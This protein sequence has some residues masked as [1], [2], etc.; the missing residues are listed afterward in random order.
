MQRSFITA[1]GAVLA[2]ASSLCAP[3]IGQA[4]TT[5]TL[6]LVGPGSTTVTG[7]NTEGDQALTVSN[8]PTV[9]AYLWRRGTQTNIGGLAPSP[10]FV[11]SGGLNDLVQMVGTTICPKSGNFCGFVWSQGHMRE[12]PTPAGSMAAFGI[13]VNLLGQIVGQVYDANFNAQAALWNQGTLTLLP[14]IPGGSFSQPVGINIFG[15]IV[16]YSDDASNVPNT[17]L[18]RHGALT[19]LLK[20][21]IPGAVNDEGQIVGTLLGSVRPFLWQDGMTTQL[22]APRGLAPT[23]VASGINDWGQIVGSMS[24]VAILWQNGTPID[25]NT[26][27][28]RNDPLRRFVYLQ[29]ATQI[30]NVGQIVANGTDSRN[31]AAVGVWYLLTPTH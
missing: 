11:E 29:G 26:R 13:Q 14:G 8:G 30:N 27:I 4:Q 3:A 9:A 1:L 16:G 24:S 28:A 12:L 25:L 22:P 15:D 31:S 20:N 23:G 19:V 5:Y 6:T 21:S 2:L 18:W 10:Q 17:V 7:L